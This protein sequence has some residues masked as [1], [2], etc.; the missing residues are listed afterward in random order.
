MRHMINYA[1]LIA[2]VMALLMT[3]Y[4]AYLNPNQLFVSEAGIEWQMIWQTFFSW[5]MPLAISLAVGAALGY[6]LFRVIKKGR[7]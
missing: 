4:D 5:F 6:W 7:S 1:L 3:V 2:L